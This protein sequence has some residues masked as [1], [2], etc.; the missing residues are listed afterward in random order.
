MLNGLIAAAPADNDWVFVHDAARPCVEKNSIMRLIETVENEAVDG[1]I[2]AM[3]VS[4]TIKWVNE[5]G[6]I[7]KT[8]DRSYC[9]RAQTPQVF[10]AATLIEALRE[11]QNAVTDESSAMEI[12]GASVKVVEGSAFNVKV[13]YPDDIQIVRN[14][15]QSIKK[16]K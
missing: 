2:L 15:L 16:D 5:K 8:I 10:Q 7:E 14:Y 1:A 4:D 3:P 12:K 13:T 6:L 9:F 11:A